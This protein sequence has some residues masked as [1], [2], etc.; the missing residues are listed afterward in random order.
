MLAKVP[1]FAAL[2]RLCSPVV[3][4]LRSAVPAVPP[5]DWSAASVGAVLFE[6]VGVYEL[7]AYV[8]SVIV[9]KKV[10]KKYI[11]EH[12]IHHNDH[13][14]KYYYENCN[15]SNLINLFNSHYCDTS[16]ALRHQD[17]SLEMCR[18]VLVTMHF[19]IIECCVGK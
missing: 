7:Y 5:A 17:F 19:V 10:N 12:S 2:G 18:D 11:F 14:T 4:V 8:L 13:C 15:T 1:V 16:W 9:G 3:A 6:S